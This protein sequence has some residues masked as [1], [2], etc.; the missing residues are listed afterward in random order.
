MFFSPGFDFDFLSIL[1]KRLVGKSVYD[2]TYLVSSGMLKM[3]SVRTAAGQWVVQ[4]RALE[5]P[6]IL[7]A[8]TAVVGVVTERR[9]PRRCSFVAPTRTRRASLPA[10]V[11]ALC[12]LEADPAP[13]HRAVW[14]SLRL[15]SVDSS[16]TRLFLLLRR[17]RHVLLQTTYVKIMQQM[18]R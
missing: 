1:A 16:I 6:L 14:A 12:L 13:W 11:A 5:P 8:S 15:D 10:F 3:N 2:M 9:G 4:S 7:A 17:R 18:L